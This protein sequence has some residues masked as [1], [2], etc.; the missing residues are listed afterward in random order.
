MG[1]EAA[2]YISGLNSSNPVVGDN[3]TEGDDHLR[4]IKG[5]LLATFPNVT[6]AVTATHTE[7]NHVDGVTSAIQTQL[8]AKAD[9]TGDEF[10]GTVLVN[11]N[12]QT[13]YTNAAI[14]ARSTS[15]DVHIALH[16]S[17]ATVCSIK[18]ARGGSGI[19]V[20]GSD[21]AT[22]VPV[23]A[24]DFTIPSDVRLKENLVP[25]S[26]SGAIVDALTG[27]RFQYKASGKHSIGLSAQDVR[28]VMPELVR[29]GDGGY[30]EVS[31]PQIVAA[32]TEELKALR[33]RVALLEAQ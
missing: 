20:V 21:G 17:G 5:T 13:A 30:L 4:L 9:L 31:Y 33:K 3:K 6:G 19:Q 14:E 32:L 12:S 2:T 26:D 10:T 18:H 11:K 1:L 24:S 29:E 15:G 22:H 7:L 27:Y 16:A 8:D 23:A 28:E 25:L